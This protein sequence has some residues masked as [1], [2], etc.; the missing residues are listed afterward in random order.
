MSWSSGLRLDMA[1]RRL[2]E[3]Q[4]SPVL[5]RPTRPH[6]TAEQLDHLAAGFCNHDS[7]DERAR[8][9]C[10]CHRGPSSTPVEHGGP[11]YRNE[12]NWT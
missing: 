6:L 11:T 5:P 12:G 8:C 7:D 3:Q 4:S 9:A 1:L 2:A 10:D